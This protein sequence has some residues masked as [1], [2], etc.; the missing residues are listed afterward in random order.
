MMDIPSDGHLQRSGQCLEY[1]FYLM[2][3]IVTLGLDV[4]VHPGTVTKALEKME[5][6][7]RRHIAY[8]FAT[9]LS[10]PYQPRPA[11][12]IEC[13]LC[14]TIVHRQTETIPLYA[15]LVAQGLGNT[16]SQ[17]ES[18]ILNRMMLIHMQVTL[19]ADGQVHHAMPANLLQHVVKES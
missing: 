16:L 10:L 19:A 3:L 5:E 6:H 7:L 11:S 14:Q 12:E 4:H 18:R 13:H 8:P 2:V 9:E 17:G 1:A 15:T